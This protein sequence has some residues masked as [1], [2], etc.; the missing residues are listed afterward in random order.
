M[1]EYDIYIQWDVGMTP[2]QNLPNIPTVNK[3]TKL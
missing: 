1:Y 3:Y 2:T